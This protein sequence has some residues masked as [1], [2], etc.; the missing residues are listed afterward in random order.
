MLVVSVFA[1][2]LFFSACKESRSMSESNAVSSSPASSTPV[3]T[4]LVTMRG[5]PVT[6]SGNPVSVGQLAPDF[7]ALDTTMSPHKLS[8]YRGKVVILSSVPSLD[9]PVCDVETRTFNEKL[10]EL[11]NDVVVLTVS[12][13][14]PFAQKRWCG[15]HGIDRVVTLSDFKDRQFGQHFGLS[16]VETGLLARAVMVIDK[17][18]TI[19]YEQ[20]VP[21]IASEPDYDAAIAAAKTALEAG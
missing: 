13:D 8:E 20:I 21:E 14:L 18:G 6:L 1:V 12:M 15:A 16:M 19:V 10:S 17:K 11:G 4:G 9:T 7:V 2:T 5:N 3:R